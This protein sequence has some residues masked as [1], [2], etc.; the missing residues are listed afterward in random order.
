M[1]IAAISVIFFVKILTFFF[2]LDLCWSTEGFKKLLIKFSAAIGLGMG[3]SSLAYF[4]YRILFA[5]KFTFFYFE[6][7]VFLVLLAAWYWKRRI[8]KLPRFPKLMLSQMVIGVLAA[9]V[10]LS[11]LSGLASY[12]FTRQEGD[13]DAWMIYNRAAR[14]IHRGGELWR[15]AFSSKI[16]PI[17]HADYPPMLA[18]NIASVWDTVN[19][20]SRYV[21]LIQGLLFSVACAFALTSALASLKSPAQAGLSLIF[22]WGTGAFVYEGGRQTADV[23]LAFFILAAI[24]LFHLYLE[25]KKTILL[26][27]AGFSAGLA[28]WTKNEGILF[29]FASLIFLLI[30]TIRERSPK[31]VLGYLLGLVLPFSAV[32][33]FKLLVSPVDQSVGQ[34]I[35][36]LLFK[37]LL[38]S[39]KSELSQ[40]SAFSLIFDPARHHA[41]LEAFNN[42]LM[43]YGPQKIPFFLPL[44]IIYVVTVFARDKS[45]DWHHV[46]F[47]G[48]IATQIIGYYFVYLITPNDLDWQIKFSIMRLMAQLYPSIIFT[49]LYLSK[50]PEELLPKRFGN[51]R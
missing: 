36:S 47:P 27:L 15:D 37:S 14:F 21:P 46:Y 42:I 48:I 23:P 32:I 12:A 11:S 5:E 26:I 2:I 31:V 20:E 25:E 38:V 4:I 43:S 1:L 24:I 39:S 45:G 51:T 29:L 28:A 6:I 40:Q 22:L 16:D 7:F 13:W 19:K 8:F 50:T 17:F 9:I 35:S 3:G 44:L 49:A 33:Y 18:L 41:I 30:A 10:F 34:N